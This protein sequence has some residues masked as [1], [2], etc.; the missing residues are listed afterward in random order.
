MPG[1]GDNR[2][3]GRRQVCVMTDPEL[4]A[5]IAERF[6]DT[7]KLGGPDLDGVYRGKRVPA[8]L[9]LDGLKD[10]FA[11]CD[12]IFGWDIAEELVPDLKFTGWETGYPD[13]IARPDLTTFRYVPWEVGVASVICDYLDEHGRPTAISPRY[14]L[15]RVLERVGALGYTTRLALELE[16]RIFREDQRSLRAKGWQNLE[17]LSPTNSCYSIHRATGDDDILARIRRMMQDHGLQ[18][19]G[20]NREHGPGMYEMNL[21]HAE[22]IAAADQAMLFR[23]GVKE[24]CGQAGLTA[25]FMAKWS[26]REDGSSGHLHQ[27][28]WSSGGERN[29]FYD[30]DGDHRLSELA[31][32][33]A[34]GVLRLLPEFQVLYAS[35]INSY[36]R[37]QAGTWAPTGVTWG[38][39]TRTTALRMVPGSSKSTR[40]ENRVPGADANPYL[41]MAAS[42]A[43]GLYGIEHRLALPPAARGNAYDLSAGAAPPLNRTL[44]EAVERFAASEAAVEYFGPAFV[45]HFVAMRRWEVEQYNRVVDRWQL[46]RYLE[47]V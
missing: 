2:G 27:S 24:M 20:Y 43:A 41:A 11:Q 4:R 19:E 29:L 42:V 6:V 35:N 3:G 14:V 15:Q 31:R 44:N 18:I 45:D 7:I 38:I 28:L 37:Y 12:V 5:L 32:H 33:Y 1:S 22:G 25:S 40:V 23:N 8:Q 9:F 10:G 13:V 17:P 26:D 30:A 34:A 46:E 47:M 39:E 21:A 36:K 16:F